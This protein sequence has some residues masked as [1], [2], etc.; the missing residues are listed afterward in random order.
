MRYRLSGPTGLRVSELFLGAMTF[1]EQGG[2]GAPPEE[3]ALILDTFADPPHAQYL[4]QAAKPT[5]I[6]AGSGLVLYFWRPS[7]RTRGRAR[8]VSSA[9]PRPIWGLRRCLSRSRLAAPL[10]LLPL[11]DADRRD[12]KHG[13][14]GDVGGRAPGTRLVP[15]QLGYPG[16][17]NRRYPSRRSS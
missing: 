7:L 17:G 2:V 16:H 8:S 5:G 13:R 10:A 14:T 12:R 4:D 6:A 1:G 15:A 9:S 11:D 3:C